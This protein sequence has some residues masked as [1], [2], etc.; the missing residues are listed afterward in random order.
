M[1]IVGQSRLMLRI[2]IDVAAERER[3]GREI[4]RVEGEIARAGAKLGN[5]R[6]AERAPAA[7]V[8]QERERLAGF[9]SLRARLVEQLRRLD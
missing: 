1:Q 6:F 8:S 4:A 2:E 9:E 3:L 7:I 5:P